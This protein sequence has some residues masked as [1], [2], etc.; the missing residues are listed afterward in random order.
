ML[1]EN[2]ELELRRI[3]VQVVSHIIDRIPEGWFR[4][5]ECGPGWTDIVL[6]CHNELNAIDPEYTPYQIKQKYG[7]LRYYYGTIVAGDEAKKM[8]DIVNKYEQM[9]STICEITGDPGSLMKK[10]GYFRT[11]SDAFLERG[12]ERVES[13]GANS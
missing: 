11:L 4:A 7:W 1:D 8:L 2:K 9:S 3:K 5:V 13:K 6:N 12:W 10:N